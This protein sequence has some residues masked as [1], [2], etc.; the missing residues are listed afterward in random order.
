MTY[1]EIQADVKKH[2]G[3][4]VK[5]CWIAH[6]KELNGSNPK[7]APNRQTSERKYPCPE[8]ARPLIESSMS[9]WSK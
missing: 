4:S 3:R 5:T 1:K 8:W 7:P 6:V 2:F 9:K